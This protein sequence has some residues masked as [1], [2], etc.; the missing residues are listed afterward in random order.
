M[1]SFQGKIVRHFDDSIRIEGQT[2]FQSR[3]QDSFTGG[4][5]GGVVG[6]LIH[7]IFF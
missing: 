3:L 5:M 6:F 7:L 4:L 2:S 1:Y